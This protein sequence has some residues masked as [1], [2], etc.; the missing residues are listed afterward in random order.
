MLCPS[1]VCADAF[2]EMKNWLHLH[3]QP[4][5]KLLD[6]WRRTAKRRLTA[7]HGPSVPSLDSILQQWPRYKDKD[8]FLLASSFTSFVSCGS[9]HISL[10]TWLNAASLCIVCFI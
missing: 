6:Y 9:C 4:Q 3:Q 2:E 8:G 5:S 1:L 7:I 10:M